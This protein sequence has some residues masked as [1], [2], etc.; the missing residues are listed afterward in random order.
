MC[1]S[2]RHFLARILEGRLD[3]GVVHPLVDALVLLT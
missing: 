2:A 1:I 3:G